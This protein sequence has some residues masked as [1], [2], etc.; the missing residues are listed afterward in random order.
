MTN[1]K[2]I[3]ARIC[4]EKLKNFSSMIFIDIESIWLI[5]YLL[6]IIFTSFIIHKYFLINLIKRTFSFLSLYIILI[7][8]LACNDLLL[9]FIYENIS[10][11]FIYILFIIDGIL[12]G[13]LL[14][15][16]VIIYSY[17]WCIFHFLL[18]III[19]FLSNYY[20]LHK[21]KKDFLLKNSSNDFILI[22][23]NLLHIVYCFLN[24]LQ[25]YM[26]RIIALSGMCISFYIILFQEFNIE[27][28]FPLPMIIIHFVQ[29]IR[30]FF[31]YSVVV[32]IRNRTSY[33]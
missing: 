30:A 33:W 8:L 2:R 29:S 19:I 9:N 31:L 20:H 21:L 16:L 5:I 12:T 10:K 4:I 3:E 32:C 11:N 23:I 15:F 27:F 13:A 28:E 14:A 18:L 7:S 26:H 1:Q 24:G 6:L 17:I 25:T 22:I